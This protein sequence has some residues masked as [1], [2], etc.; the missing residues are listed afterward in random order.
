M[1]TLRSGRLCVDG[2]TLF[3]SCLLDIG[4]YLNLYVPGLDWIL[5]CSAYR[6]VDGALD[7]LLSKSKKMANVSLVINACMAAFPP[8]YISA[9]LVT[10][11]GTR[12]HSSYR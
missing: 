11:P 3:W 7:K 9:R 1:Y 10:G 6:P 5:Q 8:E 4:Q 12:S 2:V